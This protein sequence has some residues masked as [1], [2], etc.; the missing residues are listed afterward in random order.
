MNAVATAVDT[1]T[2]FGISPVSASI[3]PIS[4]VVHLASANPTR[5]N[6]RPANGLRFGDLLEIFF[7]DLGMPDA[8]Y[9]AGL[10]SSLNHPLRYR[11]AMCSVGAQSKC[12]FG[13]KQ[14]CNGAFVA[15]SGNEA[16]LGS[17]VAALPDG[18]HGIITIGEEPVMLSMDFDDDDL[19]VTARGP[20]LMMHP[21]RLIAHRRT[22]DGTRVQTSV[23]VP[24]TH[25]QGEYF[26]ARVERGHLDRTFVGVVG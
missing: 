5:G 24:F 12:L 4:N 9:V 16:E 18:V 10:L 20:D 8:T 11:N 25:S 19:V 7:G 22:T 3:Q 2:L 26:V 6:L 15:T 14:A 23:E 13:F 1:G 17:A 21:L